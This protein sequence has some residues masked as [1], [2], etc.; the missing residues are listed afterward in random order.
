MTTAQNKF[1]EA[2]SEKTAAQGAYTNGYDVAKAEWLGDGNDDPSQLQPAVYDADGVLV[3]GNDGWTEASIAQLQ[4]DM[5]GFIDSFIVDTVSGTTVVDSEQALDDAS[6]MLEAA[7]GALTDAEDLRDGYVPAVTAGDVT[8]KQGEVSTAKQ[9]LEVADQAVIDATVYLV[10][11]LTAH[12][13]VIEARDTAKGTYDDLAEDLEDL[14][15]I[16][17]LEA[18][19][20]TDRT[21]R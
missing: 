2:G 4:Q 10:D 17:D 7:Q 6:G 16:L 19:A 15:D 12:E 3:S 20:I 21:L 14:E 5:D 18:A 8:A 13:D 9:E 11:G 1:N